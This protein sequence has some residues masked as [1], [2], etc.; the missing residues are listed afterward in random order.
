[1][2]HLT[3]WPPDAYKILPHQFLLLHTASRP[4]QDALL[5]YIKYADL[6]AG[7]VHEAKPKG[8]VLQASSSRLR[9]WISV[10]VTNILQVMHTH[11]RTS[12]LLYLKITFKSPPLGF[13]TVSV[14]NMAQEILAWSKDGTQWPK[15][16]I[17]D[18]VLS[19]GFAI[20]L[21]PWRQ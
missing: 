8:G 4:A 3:L 6:A 19:Q 16:F 10:A 13:L 14:K 18:L 21:S 2:P 9:E 11:T 5:G 12:P 7:F 1:M 20:C 15:C 17:S